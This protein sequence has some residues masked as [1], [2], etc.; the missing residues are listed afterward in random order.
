LGRILD[1][2]GGRFTFLDKAL[3][4]LIDSPD[5]AHAKSRHYWWQPEKPWNFG[6][7]SVTSAGASIASESEF[8]MY[9]ANS[10]PLAP[11]DTYS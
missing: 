8:W 1:Y 7:V 9:L 2:L 3:A 11:N 6:T 5:R 4:E 10:E